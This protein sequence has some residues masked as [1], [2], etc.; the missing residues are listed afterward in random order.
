M[1]KEI[2]NKYNV[3]CLA[4]SAKALSVAHEFDL[5]YKDWSLTGENDPARLVPL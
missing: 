4:E 5:E 3:I 2:E 1:S